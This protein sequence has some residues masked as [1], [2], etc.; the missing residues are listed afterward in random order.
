MLFQN[1]FKWRWKSFELWMCQSRRLYGN[2]EFHMKI[3]INF[4]SKL[5]QSKFCYPRSEAATYPGQCFQLISSDDLQ[6]QTQ[7]SSVDEVISDAWFGAPHY[8]I[9]TVDAAQMTCLH[10]C[11]ELGQPRPSFYDAEPDTWETM[12]FITSDFTCN[13]LCV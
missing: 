6:N 1:V 11:Q 8:K 4:N 5:F 10:Y 7:V 2:C 9:T 3:S 13:M 12:F